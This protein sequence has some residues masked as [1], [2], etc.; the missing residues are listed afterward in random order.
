MSNRWISYFF[1]AALGLAGCS[2]ATAPPVDGAFE[3][4]SAP[5]P[6]AVGIVPIELKP[7]AESTEFIATIRSLQSTTVQP[8]AEGIV[9]RIFVQSGERVEAGQPLLQIDPERQEAMVESLESLKAAREADVAFARQQFERMRSLYEEGVVSRQDLEVA[10]TARDTSEAQLRNIE[11]Q[12]R[13]TRVELEYYRLTA[14]AGGILG[15]LEIRQGDRVTRDTVVTTIDEAESMEAYIAVP[16]E[17]APHLRIGL[18]VELI[19]STGSVSARN[20]ITFIAPRADDSTQSV[21]VKSRLVNVPQGV[22][23]LQY[24]RARIVWRSD[25]GIVVPV[26]AISRVSGQYFVFTVEQGDGE[27]YVARQKPV[28]L[29]PLVDGGYVVRD[30]LEPGERVVVSNLQKILD[31]APVRIEE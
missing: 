25:P 24:V 9:R 21:L 15:D 31:G 16:I 22:R 6:V 23:V 20:Q 28:R 11:S 27:G 8:Q 26:T 17:Q 19:D 29:G 5:P 12:V 13:E 2:D 18:P 30:G 4:G 3:G 10:E 14:P 7:I 1:S